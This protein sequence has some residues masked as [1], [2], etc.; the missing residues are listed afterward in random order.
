MYPGQDISTILQIINICESLYINPKFGSIRISMN[1]TSGTLPNFEQ[2]I[3]NKLSSKYHEISKLKPN[4]LEC[5]TFDCSSFKQLRMFTDFIYNG[6]NNNNEP[7]DFRMYMVELNKIEIIY[8]DS[9]RSDKPKYAYQSV[10]DL[11]YSF[12]CTIDKFENKIK[13]HR[14]AFVKYEYMFIGIPCNFE[15]FDSNKRI[16][17]VA[18]PRLICNTGYT[19]TNKRQRL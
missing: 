8:H 11:P 19:T 13:M 3:N 5:I 7:Q 15:L 18:L 14:D 16:S 4:S 6:I 9:S 2:L 12:I 1:Y 10:F 17:A